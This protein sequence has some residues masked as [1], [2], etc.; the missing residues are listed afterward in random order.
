MKRTGGGEERERD[1]RK[2]AGRER[3]TDRHRHTEKERGREKAE[4]RKQGMTGRGRHCLRQQE[5]EGTPL[6]GAGPG[7]PGYL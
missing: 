5:A 4:N 6:Q 7:W 3:D 1:R 2:E